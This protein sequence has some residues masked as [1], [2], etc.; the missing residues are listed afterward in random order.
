MPSRPYFAGELR[1]SS[2]LLE[3]AAALDSGDE[4]DQEL[5]EELFLMAAEPMLRRNIQ[6]I[7][8]EKLSVERLTREA[9]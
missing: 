6:A 7:G 2:V 3:F 9:A 5:A 8:P 1:E 4:S